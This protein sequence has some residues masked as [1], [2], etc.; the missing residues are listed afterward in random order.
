MDEQ[1]KAIDM[2]KE[3]LKQWL[4][5]LSASDTGDV[6]VFDIDP[7]LNHAITPKDLSCVQFNA[8]GDI[9]IGNPSAC[10][11]PK[12]TVSEEISGTIYTVTGSYEG[13]E[14]FLRKLE[15]IATKKFTNQ[16]EVDR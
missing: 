1:K 15:R 2:T 16:L 10:W 13:T 7:Y 5:T 14:S 8:T 6:P 3:E 4:K 12:L 9:F 11:I